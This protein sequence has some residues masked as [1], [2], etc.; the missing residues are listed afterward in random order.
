ME[1]L[2]RNQFVEI[3]HDEPNGWLH[4]NWKGYQIDESIKEGCNRLLDFMTERQT[5][6]V[7]NDNTHTQGIWLGVSSW[8]AFDALPRARQI[9]MRSFA[10]VYGPSRMSRIS[11]NAAL[12]L[13]R[14]DTPDV[15]A[16]EDIE[17][18]KAW[19]RSLS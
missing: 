12:I 16:F 2:L 13:L 1:M 10:H 15:R 17:D 7:L 4:M 9:G 19:L 11:A 14:S 6:K 18:A 3:C 8:L 5:F